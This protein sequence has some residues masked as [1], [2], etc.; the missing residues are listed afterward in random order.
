MKRT[1]RV[2][3]LILLTTTLTAGNALGQSAEWKACV[4]RSTSNHE[5]SD[6]GAAEIARQEARLIL[7]LRQALAC[8]NTSDASGQHTREAFLEEQHLWTRF[9]DA[10]CRFYYP[11]ADGD[12]PYFGR[13]GEV[14]DA[15]VCRATIME[16]RSRWLEGFAK[17]CTGN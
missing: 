11:N 12:L 13:E 14:L 6:C 10:A 1:P 15:P 9:K 3:P 4:D 7:A 8:F 5:W 17:N 16:D 2:V